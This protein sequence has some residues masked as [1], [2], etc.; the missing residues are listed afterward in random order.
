MANKRVT[1][2][3]FWTCDELTDNGMSHGM[4]TKRSRT[5]DPY[6]FLNKQI[7]A[8]QT[9]NAAGIEVLRV[10]YEVDGVKHCVLAESV[11][12]LA[13]D[14]DSDTTAPS[15]KFSTV[16]YIRKRHFNGS[17]VGDGGI[18]VWFDVDHAKQI[19]HY[20][21][22]V[23][24]H[25]DLFE[26]EH[27]RVVASR[28]KNQGIGFSTRYHKDANLVANF[29][30]AFECV[31]ASLRSSRRNKAWKSKNLKRV[32]ADIGSGDSEFGQHELC[33]LHR[34]IG[35]KKQIRR[36]MST[37]ARWLISAGQLAEN[38]VA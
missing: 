14:S 30:A 33:V 18:T 8:H 25:G 37:T 9:S 17:P 13:E 10:E 29:L 31:E 22:A 4:Y 15:A 38:G 36:L 12:A 34:G 2:T 19:V 24:A 26:K 28:R 7:A 27:G 35:T 11:P 1:Y 20:Y 32:L 6:Q 23:C 16:R 5:T 3:V 21:F